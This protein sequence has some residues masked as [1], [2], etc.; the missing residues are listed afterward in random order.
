MS[1]SETFEIAKLG[2]E[3]IACNVRNFANGEK[4]F[5]GARP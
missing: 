1:F 3:K 4:L 5:V 2:F